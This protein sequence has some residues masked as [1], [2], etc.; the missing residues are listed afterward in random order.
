MQTDDELAYLPARRLMDLLRE[1]QVSSR[2]LLQCY[3]DRIE[4]FNPAVNAIVSLDEERATARASAADDAIASGILWGPLH[5]LPITVKDVFETEGLRTTAGDPQLSDYVPRRDAVLVARLRRAGAVVFGKT[6]TPVLA[7]GGQTFNP[8]FGTTNNPWN[9]S[10]TPGGSSGGCAA[11]LAAGLTPLSFGSD[12]AGSIRIP[13]SFCGVYGHKPTFGLV[14]PR[15]HIPGPPGELVE[16]DINVVGPLARDALD[17]DLALSVLAGPLSQEALGWRMEL[18]PPFEKPLRDWRVAAWLDD[19][20]CPVDSTVRERL[21]AAAT[22]LRNI[23]A[24][25]DTDAKPNIEFADAFSLYQELRWQR[26]NEGILHSEWLDL[27]DKRQAYR[28]KWAQFFEEYDVLLCPVCSTPPFKHDQRPRELLEYIIDG[29]IRPYSDYIAWPGIIGMAYLPSTST[30]LGRNSNGLPVGVQVVGPHLA[31][32]R[33][34]AFSRLL[35]EV[36]GGFERP[37]SF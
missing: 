15:G 26:T 37:P 35:A 5:G 4:R 6:N 10:L 11:A 8:L 22:A 23:G 3:L 29:Q 21:S 1:K 24:Y 28:D 2:E 36:F 13:A 18:A 25:V 14:P 31:D 34:I 20:A 17:L 33:T 32:R 19:A 30:P 27:D 12:V 7:G 9:L 16:R